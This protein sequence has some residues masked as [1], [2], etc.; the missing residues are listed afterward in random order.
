MLQTRVYGPLSESHKLHRM[1]VLIQCL[2][3]S[4]ARLRDLGMEAF[5]RFLTAERKGLV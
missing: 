1:T 5:L 2:F 3:K 4:K